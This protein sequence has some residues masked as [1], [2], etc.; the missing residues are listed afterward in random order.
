[1]G[2]KITDSRWEHLQTEH[3]TFF[4]AL[5]YL[6]G[7]PHLQNTEDISGSVRCSVASLD[8]A[9]FDRYTFKKHLKETRYENYLAFTLLP[10]Y[11]QPQQFYLHLSWNF[12]GRGRVL[13]YAYSESQV[14]ELQWHTLLP[15]RA[16]SLS[17]W[18]HIWCFPY[19]RQA[20]SL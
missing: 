3:R 1:M 7:R 8:A 19:H 14:P 6:A 13:D 17:P 18:R 11:N 2:Q 12:V 5:Q 4:V 9:L 16:Q 15:K 10:T 20:I